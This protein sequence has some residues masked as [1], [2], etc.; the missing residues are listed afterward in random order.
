MVCCRSMRCAIALI[1]FT[2]CCAATSLSV[3]AAEPSFGLETRPAWKNE[4]LLGFPD[5]LPPYRVVRAYPEVQQ[6]K[7]LAVG[8]FP[9]G[10]W[11][12][13]INHDAD[14]GG[15]GRI[16][17]FLDQATDN[18]TEVLIEIPEIVYG[19]AFHP[20]FANNGF[21]FVGCNGRSEALDAVATK[22]LRFTLDPNPPFNLQ[23]D[24]RQLVIEWPSNGHNG[25]DLT[26]ANDGMLYVSAGDGTS[27]SDMNLTAQ[28]LSSINGSMIRIDVDHPADGKLYSVPSDNPFIN[29]EGARP[30]IWAFGL[31][32]PWRVTYDR[33]SD[34]LWVG[35]NGQ[36]LWETA[37]LIRK[38]ENYGWS[39][40]E[41][42]HPFQIER[43]QGPA[44]FTPPTVEHHHSEARSLTGGIVY[45]GTEFP[46][47][48]GA[49]IYGDYATGNIWAVKHNGTKVEWQKHLARSTLQ[50]S[51]FGKAVFNELVIVD[52]EG[53]L[54]RLEPQTMDPSTPPFP[55]RLSQTGLYKDVSKGEMASGLIPY[56]VLS[57]LWSDGA[58]KSRWMAVPTEQQ[59]DMTDT[60]GWNFPAQS[61]LVKTFTLPV[62]RAGQTHHRRIETRLMVK[63]D[64]E[65]FGYSYAWNEDESD[66]ELVDASG[67]DYL[68]KDLKFE[69]DPATTQLAWHFPSRNECM[70]CHSRAANYV[71]GL[72]TAQM[73]RDH[74]Y[75]A[76]TDNQLRTLA[77]IGLLKVPKPKKSEANETASSFDL[78]KAASEYK[79]LADPADTSRPLEARVKAYLQSNCA[80]CHTNAGGGNSRMELAIDT[81]LEKM[82]IVD[83]EP[84]HDRFKIEDARIV[85]PGSPERSTMFH[86]MAKR[87][88]GQMPPMATGRV[89]SQGTALMKSWIESLKK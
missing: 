87:G 48:V 69:D 38:G 13:L 78:P 63:V 11:M 44:P 82:L 52:H 76:G 3:R 46:E 58:G 27:D 60:W 89:D 41:G 33:Q 64:K 54:Y 79:Q 15:N 53:G 23:P 73:N 75:A 83:T 39:V 61:V 66:A 29:I 86:R 74:E 32:N 31:R 88:P 6:K 57:P 26:F 20:D 77:H 85:A 62:N 1:L 65:W 37:H 80:H 72:S 4:R 45:R 36:D 24:S 19:V 55:R 7:L 18:A 40:M 49:Y 70:V 30:E 16:F 35:N 81:P 68:F 34:Q 42:S 28:D 50:I 47:L 8:S 9:T 43:K 67:R 22:V 5:P 10:P 51:G 21:V 71:L 59:V 2:G 12:W 17:R 56:S 14:Y 25:G 84:Q